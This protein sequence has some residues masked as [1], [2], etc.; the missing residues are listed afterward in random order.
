MIGVD[1]MSINIMLC[2]AACAVVLA[3]LD[4][5]QSE[6]QEQ[7]PQGPAHYA[8]QMDRNPKDSD[9]AVKVVLTNLPT[10]VQPG[11]VINLVGDLT[12]TFP[13]DVAATSRLSLATEAALSGTT[14]SL[15]VRSSSGFIVIKPAVLD[16]RAQPIGSVL[17]VEARIR[18]QRFVVP[19][20]ARGSLSFTLPSPA[21]RTEPPGTQPTV[22]EFTAIIAQDS[23]VQPS[24]NASCKGRTNSA[25]FEV[26][27]TTVD[28]GGR[29]SDPHVLQQGSGAH[30]RGP[31]TS[32]SLAAVIGATGPGKLSEGLPETA[33]AIAPTVAKQTDAVVA[34]AS[35]SLS[36]T[37]GLI[38]PQTRHPGTFIPTWTLLTMMLTFPVAGLAYAIRRRGTTGE[39]P[40][41]KRTTVMTMISSRWGARNGPRRRGTTP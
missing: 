33:S 5:A 36:R 32:P 16:S 40:E 19:G 39:S 4:P 23:P 10:S 15:G 38:P 7:P 18:F 26:G 9:T 6:A 30:Q 1:R 25:P 11:Q 22:A 12:L 2:A 31:S 28:R 29:A 3:V 13:A 8:C 14:F 24:R 17:A 41:V 27:R 35:A 20:G 34:D 37:T 21:S